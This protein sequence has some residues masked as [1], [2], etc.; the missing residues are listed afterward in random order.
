MCS[1]VF[2]VDSFLFLDN[3]SKKE[4]RSAKCENDGAEYDRWLVWHYL[5]RLYLVYLKLCWGIGLVRLLNWEE[6]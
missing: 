2:V 4:A 3:I 1:R 6:K 5:Y